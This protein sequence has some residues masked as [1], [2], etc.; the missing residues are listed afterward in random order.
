LA[1]E[2]RMPC[3]ALFLVL[4]FTN[5]VIFHQSN[6]LFVLFMAGKKQLSGIVDDEVIRQRGLPAR[7]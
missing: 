2:Y 7:G 4:F 5:G 1:P 3:I 6:L